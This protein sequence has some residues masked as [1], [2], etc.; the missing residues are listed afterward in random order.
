MDLD[1]VSTNPE[2]YRVLVENARVRVLEYSVVTGH[3]IE[4]VF[5]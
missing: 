3:G 4:H 2:A 5:A 1:P